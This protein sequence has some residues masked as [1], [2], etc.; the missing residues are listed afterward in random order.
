MQ[1]NHAPKAFIPRYIKFAVQHH[2]QFGMQLI[3]SGSIKS[4]GG[5]ANL[6]QMLM[7]AEW[8]LRR[9][10]KLRW[11]PGDL[12]IVTVRESYKD[13]FDKPIEFKFVVTNNQYSQFSWERGENRVIN[14]SSTQRV[15]LQFSIISC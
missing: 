7:T 11:K 12:W 15:P 10:R 4:L 1:N 8:N 2:V 9:G 3:L 6:C 5:I 14:I 13:E